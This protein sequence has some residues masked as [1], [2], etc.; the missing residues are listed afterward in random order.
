MLHTLT[1][2]SFCCLAKAAG[3]CYTEPKE[4]NIKQKRSFLP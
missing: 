2:G 4:T 3:P 1:A